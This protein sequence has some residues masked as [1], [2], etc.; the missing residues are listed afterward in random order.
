MSTQAT[1]SGGQPAGQQEAGEAIRLERATAKR[2]ARPVWSGVDLSVGQGEFVAVLGPNG[3]GKTTLNEYL[4]TG[5]GFT[6]APIWLDHDGNTAGQVSSWFSVVQDGIEGD[7]PAL[8][9]AQ[10]KADNARSA[11]LAKDLVHVPKGDLVIRNARL[12]DPRDLSVTANTSVLVRGERIVRIAP[13]GDLKDAATDAATLA[14]RAGQLRD[15][16]RFLLRGG[17]DRIRVDA[18]AVDAGSNNRGDQ[19]AIHYRHPPFEAM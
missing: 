4:I 7:I 1:S 10:D 3:G 16:L 6:P 12:F 13:D 2:G 18:S 15:E 19:I 14:R 17:D 9:D 11:R 5:L 8:N